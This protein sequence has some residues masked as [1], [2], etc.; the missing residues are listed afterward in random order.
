M[1]VCWPIG[2]R[3][4]AN[5]VENN[6]W[7]SFFGSSDK[8]STMIHGNGMALGTKELCVGSPSSRNDRWPNTIGVCG[9]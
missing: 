1:A 7:Y 6:T 9:R 2:S 8:W 5:E 4:L 3:H